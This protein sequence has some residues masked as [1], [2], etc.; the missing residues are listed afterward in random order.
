M[1]LDAGREQTKAKHAH[2]KGKSR[3]INHGETSPQV[4]LPDD[5]A[6]FEHISQFDNFRK[7]LKEAVPS[8]EAEELLMIYRRLI[9]QL[10][11]FDEIQHESTFGEIADAI[12]SR[13]DEQ[14]SRF[15]DV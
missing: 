14:L 2:P 9:P 12:F 8:L 3:T 4:P 10:L 1:M 13:Y 5:K 6:I 7:C 15:L 11:A